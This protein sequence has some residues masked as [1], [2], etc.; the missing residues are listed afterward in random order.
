MAPSLFTLPVLVILL[1]LNIGLVYLCICIRGEKKYCRVIPFFVC[2]L[3]TVGI[4]LMI[5][6]NNDPALSI[7]LSKLQYVF[8]WA[9]FIFAP[10]MVSSLTN[11]KLKSELIVIFSIFAITTGFFTIFSDLIISSKSLVYSGILIAKAGILYPFV[12]T[13]LFIISIYYYGIFMKFTNTLRNLELRIVMP[14]GLGLCIIGGMLDYAGKLNGTPVISWLTDPFSI[15]ML[16]ISLSFGT[17]ILLS[18]SEIISD[19]RNSLKEVEQLLQKN[20]QTFNEFVQ[21]IAKTIDAKDKYTAGHSMRVAEY[22]VRIARVLNLKKEQIAN[23]R[24]A[25]L[26]HDIGKIGVPDG[27]LNKKTPLSAKDRS[28][29]YQHPEIGKR[30]LSQVSDFQ[31]IL[32]IIYAHHER[33]DGTGYPNG[34][35][36]EEIP[37][38]AKILAVADAYD[39]MLSERPY[40]PA[41]TQIEAIKELL[42]AKGK[43][44]DAHIVDKFIDILCQEDNFSTNNISN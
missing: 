31:S 9:Y 30:I 6:F 3:I 16:S 19:Y 22:A 7:I 20:H 36:Q 12:A 15:G 21:L 27:I 23:L 25:C 28:Y 38:L 10:M 44:F 14:I 1:F 13:L 34:L 37:L 18:Y 35:K 24:Q 33:V 4:Q 40:R 5:E 41:K 17:F 39:A 11:Q 26:L 42:N 43:Q 32:H 8:F 2:G 29:I